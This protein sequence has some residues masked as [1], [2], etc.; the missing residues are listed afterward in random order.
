MENKYRRVECTAAYILYLSKYIIEEL[1][2]THT[3]VRYGINTLLG[4]ENFY[5]DNFY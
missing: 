4:F 3:T 1:F 2:D 5:C